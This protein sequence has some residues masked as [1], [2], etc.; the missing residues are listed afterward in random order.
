M[1]YIKLQW[2][3]NIDILIRKLSKGLYILRNLSQCVSADVLRIEY[4]AVFHPHLTYAILAWGHL[5]EVRRTFGL[6]RKGARILTSMGYR[7]NCRDG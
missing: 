2:G 7:D 3:K 5:A 4:F 6:Q 1:I